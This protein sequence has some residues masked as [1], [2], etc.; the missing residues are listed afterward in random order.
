MNIRRL[1]TTIKNIPV[2]SGLAR[3]V[4]Q[5]FF[6]SVVLF[7]TSNQYW[8]KR[9]QTNGDS[10][11]GS[12]GRLAAFKAQVIGDFASKKGVETVV[13]FGCGDGAQLM[14]MSYPD[15]IGVDVSRTI[16]SRC[17][18]RFASDATKKFYHISDAEVENLSCQMALSLDVIYHLVEDE[19]FEAHLTS[20]FAAASEWVIIYSSNFQAEIVLPHVRHRK[21]TDWVASHQPDWELYQKIDQKY[22][23]VEGQEEVTSLADFYIFRR[24]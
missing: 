2:L 11:D 24:K 17:R 7:E 19:V 20:V 6:K 3:F 16:L 23:F 5:R 18:E 15:Y 1:R 14:R 10:G 22:P 12:Y 4:Y 9:Y 8:E 13:E 21:F